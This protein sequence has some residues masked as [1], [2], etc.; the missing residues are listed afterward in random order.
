MLKQAGQN[1]KALCPFHQEK[2]PSFTVSPGRNTWHCFG[3]QKGGDIFSFVQEIEGVD[4]PAALKTLAE[5]AGIQLPAGTARTNSRRQRLFDVMSAAAKFYQHILLNQPAGKRARAYLTERGV[6]DKT[7]ADWQLGYAPDKWDLLQSWLGKQGFSLEEIIIAGLAG[8]SPRGKMYDLFRGRII[9]PVADI[10]GRIV[11]FGARI[12][13]WHETGNEGKYINSPETAL[14]EKRRVVYNL[15]R[16]KQFLRHRPCLVVEGYLDVVLLVQSGITNVVATSG[17]A[18]T[19]DHV[20]QIKRF[21]NTVHFAFDADAAGYKATVAATTAA[22]AAGLKVAT[23][24]LPAGH[25]PAD[26]AVKEPENLQKIFS[27]PQ[28]LIAVL[29]GQLK[30]SPASQTQEQQL[31]ALLPLIARVYNPI[32]QGAMRQEVAH[33]LHVSE[34]AIVNM[35]NQLPTSSAPFTAAPAASG[36]TSRASHSQ[37]AAA[38]QLLLGLMIIDAKVRQD[39]FPYLEASFLLDPNCQAL[40]NSM[41]RLS[42]RQPEFLSMSSEQVVSNLPEADVPLA[43]G[44]QTRLQEHL[45]TTSHTLMHEG[46]LLLR[47]LQRRSLK[48]RLNTLQQ[49]L[50]RAGEE[51]RTKALE[52]FQTLAEELV[53]IDK[54]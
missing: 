45:A 33:I 34:G 36:G 18:F 53:N 2:T 1:L 19:E 49:E 10:Q 15:A 50:T 4:F 27:Q 47:S 30:D 43:E 12:V 20:S 13:P 16:A 7:A 23:I 39:I 48:T 6:Q 32:E 54:V 3:C 26:L 37:D 40:Y 51:G 28:S 38:E 8:R 21:T 22:L 52:R 35:M 25:D 31:Q 41:Q 11:A 14:Y 9:F 44:I 29:I 24:V 46:R 17:T 5:R 42:A